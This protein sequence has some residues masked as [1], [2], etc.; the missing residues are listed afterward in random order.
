MSGELL[1]N[2]LL[3]SP[4]VV[5]SWTALEPPY[6]LVWYVEANQIIFLSAELLS[7]ARRSSFL[8]T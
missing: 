5:L 7:P 8:Q 1:T 6:H 3:Y 2:L 4:N